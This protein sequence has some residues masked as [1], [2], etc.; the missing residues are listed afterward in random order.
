MFIKS[1]SIL[2]KELYSNIKNMSV[3]NEV[4]MQWGHKMVNIR[5]CCENDKKE[6]NLLNEG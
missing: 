3:E 1:R 6:K 5:V 2:I 4:Y